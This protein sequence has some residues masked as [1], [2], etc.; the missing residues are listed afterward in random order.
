M[1]RSTRPL[2]STRATDF[3][4]CAAGLSRCVR[5]KGKRHTGGCLSSAGILCRQ[6]RGSLL[7]FVMG[8]AGQGSRF[9]RQA[10]A[11]SWVCRR[12]W[13]GKCSALRWL[14]QHAAQA[15]A[16]RFTGHRTAVRYRE[17]KGGVDGAPASRHLPPTL[18]VGPKKGADGVKCGCDVHP[19]PP[20]VRTF[21]CGKPPEANCPIHII[22]MQIME[23]QNVI[24]SQDLEQSLTDRKS[25]V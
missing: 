5:R 14:M 15:D 24:I 18:P 2:W 9:F 19:L 12:G 13:D 1:T 4:P 17:R 3:L 22:Y 20:K 16:A 21:A 8:L 10:C 25:V 23:K 11:A 6:S 7:A